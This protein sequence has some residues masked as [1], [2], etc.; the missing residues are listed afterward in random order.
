MEQTTKFTADCGVS[1]RKGYPSLSRLIRK[2]YIDLGTISA[3]AVVV[4]NAWSGQQNLQS[5]LN[6]ED[7][8]GVISLSI[9]YAASIASSLY[10]PLM[11]DKL[12]P[13]KS[14]LISV[15]AALL[16]YAANFYP[17]MYTLGMAALLYGLVS[18]PF[19]TCL[20]YI[21][22]TAALDNAILTGRD[23]DVVISRFNGIYWS[24]FKTT[25]ITGNMISWLVLSQAKH[26]VD[27][28]TY[29]AETRN[30]SA[31]GFSVCSVRSCPDTWETAHLHSETNSPR[32]EK[33]LVYTLL[34]IYLALVV[35][36]ILITV[37]AL[38]EPNRKQNDKADDTKQMMFATV[39]LWRD[40]KMALLLP[41][42]VF[43]GVQMAFLYAE[44]TKAFV[45]CELGIEWV[46]YTMMCYGVTSA[47]SPWVFGHLHK[48]IGF[49]INYT[50]AGIINMALFIQML[51][52][53]VS[54]EHLGYFFFIPGI[55]GVLNGMWQSRTLA[56]LGI[57]F[58]HNQRPAFANYHLWQGVGFTVSFAY[59][60]LL[61]VATKIYICMTM[62]V[63][64]LLLYYVV[65]IKTR[66]EKKKE[67][68]GQVISDEKQN[69]NIPEAE[70]L[71][72][73]GIREDDV[74]KLA[75]SSTSLPNELSIPFTQSDLYLYATDVN[76]LAASTGSMIARWD[77]MS[78]DQFR[79]VVKAKSKD[80]VHA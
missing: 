65:E 41:L 57:H 52:Y 32:P 74:K 1:V 13:K 33:S 54:K 73:N 45:A 26:K 8:I 69:G 55:W 14:I 10:A 19:F 23:G 11:V 5:S 68:S 59:G 3:I 7:G 40:Y 58:S 21:I 61:C 6:F 29:F 30:E 4:Y 51:V 49:P 76:F 2:T 20:G 42:F 80:S 56:L 12:G 79:S 35:T 28:G 25:H 22:T 47:I 60:N 67:K 18:T 63:L 16:Y 71:S 72:P 24:L 62:L 48:W 36:G 34:G 38:K 37:V 44:F 9:F 15:S 50:A 64:S 77:S 53:P 27:N 66:L 43:N 17:T 39:I 78:R 75:L 70:K 31:D 46:G